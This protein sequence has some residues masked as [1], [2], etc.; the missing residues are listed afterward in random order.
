MPKPCSKQLEQSI[1]FQSESQFTDDRAR[2]NLVQ[3]Q[4]QNMGLELGP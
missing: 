1:I 3:G 2:L 4:T